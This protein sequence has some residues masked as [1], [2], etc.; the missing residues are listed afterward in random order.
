VRLETNRSEKCITCGNTCVIKIEFREN[1]SNY[2][3][4]MYRSSFRLIS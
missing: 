2:S 4:D 1:L 3:E